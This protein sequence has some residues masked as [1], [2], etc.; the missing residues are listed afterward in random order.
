MFKDKYFEKYEFH[1]IPMGDDILMMD[2]KFIDE[3]EKSIL[4]LYNGC[5]YKSVGYISHIAVRCICENSLELSWY[6]NTTTR[7]H[8]ISIS[9]PFDQIVICVGC[10]NYGI[11]PHIIV[12]SSWLDKLF[13]RSYS[14]FALI[15]AIG[16]KESLEKGNICRS[17]LLELRNEIDSLAIK[18]QDI[19]FISFADSL[20]LKSNW[21]ISYSTDNHPNTYRPELFISIINEIQSIYTRILGLEVYAVLTQGCNEY[22][23]DSLL[24][25]SSSKNHISLNSIG[26]SFAQLM[27]IE[28]TVRKAIKEQI[29]APAEL[30]MDD[31]YFYSLLF[32]YSF[33]KHLNP[34]NQYRSKSM[35][36]CSKYYYSSRKD[37]L[38]NL[39]V[40]KQ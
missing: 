33:S 32:D 29:H 13:V 37:I 22:Y 5:E 23:D 16:V 14:V 2:E 7:S 1:E 28:N 3:F 31:S 4:D 27:D 21:Q 38:D 18:Y 17:N 39:K 20:L 25:I 40:A 9:I 8:E 24:H 11:R 15:D 35:G 36:Y 34:S 10:R 19:S 26:I 12:R 6:A 30:Y